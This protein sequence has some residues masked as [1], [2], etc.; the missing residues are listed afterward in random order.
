MNLVDEG[1]GANKKL[2]A[3]AAVTCMYKV[4][5]SLSRLVTV[6]KYIFKS[7]PLPN[8]GRHL[9]IDIADNEKHYNPR[10]SGTTLQLRTK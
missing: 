8:V 9:L 4:L 3:M 5:S 2:F 10:S 6:D 7:R 1:T